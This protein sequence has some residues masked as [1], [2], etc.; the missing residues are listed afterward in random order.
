ME[1]RNLVFSEG[2]SNKFWNITLNGTEHTVQFGKVGTAGQSQTKTFACEAEAQTSYNKLVAEKVKKGYVDA[3]ALGVKALGVEKPEVQPSL[4]QVA[5]PD[6]PK[7]ISEDTTPNAQR[8][9][10]VQPVTSNGQPATILPPPPLPRYTLDANAMTWARGSRRTALKPRAEVRPFDLADCLQRLN[11]MKERGYYEWGWSAAKLQFEMSCEEAEFWLAAMVPT[12]PI[13][14]CKK[15]GRLQRYEKPQDAAV[16]LANGKFTGTTIISQTFDALFRYTYSRSLPSEIVYPLYSLFGWA[17][18]IQ[19]THETNHKRNL[20]RLIEG[21]WTRLLPY[22]T[23][24]EIAEAQSVLRTHLSPI[25]KRTDISLLQISAQIG[26]LETEIRNYLSQKPARM[27]NANNWGNVNELLQV[28]LGLSDAEEI[29]SELHRLDLTPQSSAEAEAVLAT[30]QARCLDLICK[31]VLA[32]TDKA[33]AESMAKALARAE[34]P[35]NATYMLDILLESKAPRVGREWLD[36]NPDHAIIGLIPIAVGDQG[37]R[38]YEA[39]ELLRIYK[40]RGHSARITEQIEKLEPI[41]AQYLREQMLDQEIVNYPVLADG[42][43]PDWLRDALSISK[44]APTQADILRGGEL[45]PVPVVAGD[46]TVRL[47]NKQAGKLLAALRTSTWEQVDPLVTAVRTNVERRALNTF[48]WML[49]EKWLK[50]GA[51]S[52]AKWEMMAVG[53]LGNDASA[54]KLAPMIRVWPG[55]SQHQRAVTGLECLRAIGT[56]TALMQ[57]NGIAQKVA[58]KGLKTRAGEC[59][60]DI[61]KTRGM[62]REELEDRIVPDCEL[63]AHGTRLFDF[64]PRQFTFVLGQDMKPMIRDAEKVRRPDLPKPNSKDDP[65]KAEAA[66]AEW[67]ILKKQISDVT[68]IQLVR[69]EQAMVTGRHWKPDA[70]DL[71][72]VKHPLMTNIVRLFIWGAYGEDGKLLTTF[73]VTE[74]QTFADQNDDYLE[75][76]A[77]TVGVGIVHTYHLTEEQRNAWGEILSDYEIITP[78]PQIGRPIY[79]LEGDETHDS[80]ITRFDKIEIPA[81]TLVFTLEKLGWTRGTP[82]DAGIFSEHVKPF[83]AANVTAVVTYDGVAVGGIDELGDQKIETIFF[84]HGTKPETGWMHWEQNKAIPLAKV[85]PVVISEVLKDVISITSRVKA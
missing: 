4:A 52:K 85:D 12:L 31:A 70:F 36:A 9:T 26:G 41:L 71:L 35:E 65:E 84:I 51:P 63:D 69:L 72:L 21:I 34:T 22:M 50:D 81:T 8:P 15:L 3:G 32:Q 11:A 67:K 74:D 30:T 2:T 23:D 47:S 73:R 13:V 78:F 75:L 18:L 62:S 6:S 76:P 27:G 10:P 77:E 37:K 25:T 16:A 82:Q 60:E 79:T 45:P 40:Q 55:E 28:T 48:V 80:K 58:F 17:G 19:I 66:V 29:A 38:S 49:F 33:N 57:I 44:V 46:T 56:D 83:H 64:G 7:L 53:F 43:T 68:K 54:L 61:A 42:D 39:L 59:M 14:G 5:P 20:P 1:P 24:S